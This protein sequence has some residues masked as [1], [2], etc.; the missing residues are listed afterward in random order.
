MSQLAIWRIQ[1]FYRLIELLSKL[2]GATSAN[3]D[4]VD[5]LIRKLSQLPARP[6]DRT[7]YTGIF[8][9]KDVYAG[10][11]KAV[12]RLQ[13]LMMKLEGDGNEIDHLVDDL[14]RSLT[15]LPQRPADKQ[16]YASLFPPAKFNLLAVD[17][18]LAIASGAP[19]STVKLLV[20]QLNRTMIEFGITTP[21]RQAH[22]LAQ[23]A[24]ESDRF[25]ALEEY[26]SGSDYEWRLDLGNVFPGDGVRFKGRGLIQVTG[27]TNYGECG[28]ALGVDLIKNPKRLADPDLACRS[29]GW[30]WDS[31]KLNRD[32]DRDDV[33]KITEIINGGYNG[34]SDR[35][36]LLASA[37]RVLKA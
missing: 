30:Y 16:P 20:P 1:A 5:D 10:R 35:R 13:E 33:H 26:A 21:R 36:H 24:H 28:R 34:L 23:I 27:R 37:K 7:A 32:A 2:Q 22:F 25:R 29:A 31:R 19:A 4:K 14:I 12:E 6:A 9:V 15:Q 18:L 8:G 3:D 11:Q 17:D